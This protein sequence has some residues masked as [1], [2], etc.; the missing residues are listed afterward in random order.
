M[1]ENAE[2]PG[3][4]IQYTSPMLFP[5]APGQKNDQRPITAAGQEASGIFRRDSPFPGAA[6]IGRQSLSRNL[7]DASIAEK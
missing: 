7:P 4:G 1:M 6:R 3:Y 5:G 2:I